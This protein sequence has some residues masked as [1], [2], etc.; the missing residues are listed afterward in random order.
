MN[1]AG[2]VKSRRGLQHRHQ[3]LQQAVGLA[4]AQCT[5]CDPGLTEQCRKLGSTK[6]S[7]SDRAIAGTARDNRA[8][9]L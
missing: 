7:L 4:S 6:R 2:G 8:M 9:P 5:Q 3:L 1:D